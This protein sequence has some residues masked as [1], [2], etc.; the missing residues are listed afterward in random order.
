MSKLFSFVGGLI[1]LDNGIKEFRLQEQVI[2]LLTAIMTAARSP[3][4]QRD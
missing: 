4:R 3:D 1:V 2:G